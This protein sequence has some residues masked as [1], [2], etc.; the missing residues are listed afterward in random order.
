MP[1][2]FLNRLR[3]DSTIGCTDFLEDD[4]EWLLLQLMIEEEIEI[5]DYDAT[6]SEKSSI[7]ALFYSSWMAC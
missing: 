6:A 3:L 7:A 5:L 2:S 4:S 1:S